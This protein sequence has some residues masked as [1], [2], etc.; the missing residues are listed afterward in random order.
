MADPD[1]DGKIFLGKGDKPEM[2]A[3]AFGNR[4]GLVTGATGTGKTVTLQTIAEGFSRAGVPCSL[5]T[6]RATSRGS[7]RQAKPRT[8]S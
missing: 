7:R 2:L 3:L 6:S 8:P 5:P 4:H 1:S